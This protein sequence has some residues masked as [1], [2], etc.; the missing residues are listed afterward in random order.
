MTDKDLLA[1]DLRTAIRAA[2]SGMLRGLDDEAA[3]LAQNRITEQLGQALTHAPMRGSAVQGMAVR[4]EIAAMY[5]E[6]LRE[7][8]E[9]SG[10]PSR[11]FKGKT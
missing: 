10:R 1:G 11:G 6:V 8:S 4:A 5:D 3:T 2:L 7:M 9:A